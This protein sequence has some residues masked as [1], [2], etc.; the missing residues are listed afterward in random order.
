VHGK[1]NGGEGINGRYERHADGSYTKKI[2]HKL[3][4]LSC[5]DIAPSKPQP[6]TEVGTGEKR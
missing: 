4:A 3:P 5:P 2:E 6:T 1:R